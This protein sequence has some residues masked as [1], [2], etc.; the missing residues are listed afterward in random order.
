MITIMQSMRIFQLF[1]VIFFI[2]FI[3]NCA[4]SLFMVNIKNLA[5]IPKKKKMYLIRR[6][7]L[8]LFRKSLKVIITI[9]MSKNTG[10]ILFDKKDIIE[11]LKRA[12][13]YKY[14]I[15]S[16]ETEIRDQEM[17]KM[18]VY[19]RLSRDTKIIS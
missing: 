14:M 7:D 12:Y 5:L 13:S 18:T 19:P 11:K 2:R 10:E 6:E 17:F 15:V 3:L 9:I 1:A 4:H 16:R 8:T